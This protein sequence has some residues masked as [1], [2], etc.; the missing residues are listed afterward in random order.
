MPSFCLLWQKKGTDH[1]CYFKLAGTLEITC[2]SQLFSASEVG[3]MTTVTSIVPCRS[4]GTTFK[5]CLSTFACASC[6]C[7]SSHTTLSLQ[8]IRNKSRKLGNWGV[9]LS[10]VNLLRVCVEGGGSPSP[11]LRQW[12]Q[13]QPAENGAYPPPKK[14]GLSH[15]LHDS[16]GSL[17]NCFFFFFNSLPLKKARIVLEQWFCEQRD[18]CFTPSVD[19]AHCC[20][21]SRSLRTLIGRHRKVTSIEHGCKPSSCTWDL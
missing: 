11:C 6:S 15:S 13:Q 9:Y 2:T 21:T 1:W 17:A 16:Q 12:R 20:D 19:E 7:S 10:H 14:T 5:S 18:L 3:W 4:A 8:K